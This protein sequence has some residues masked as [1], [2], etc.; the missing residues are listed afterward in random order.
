MVKLKDISMVYDD[1]G[2]T[3]N[4]LKLKTLKVESGE[5]VAFIGSSGCGKTT[6]F[7]LIS[8]MITPTSR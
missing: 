1:N 5:K 4:A 3:I 7:N 6:L 2:T 8:G